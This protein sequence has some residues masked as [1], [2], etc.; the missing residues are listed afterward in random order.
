MDQN[1]QQS[2]LNLTAV[3]LGPGDPELVTIKGLRAIEAAG[4]IFVPR[5]RDGDASLALRIARPWLNSTRQQIVEL[6][7]PMTRDPDLL[8]PAWRAA[9][10]QIADELQA[11]GRAAGHKAR[12]A[13]LLLG[14]PLL[15]GTFIY[16]WGELAARYPQIAVTIIPGVTS[17]AAAAAR[18]GIPLG[19]T[20][21]RVSIVPASYETDAGQLRRLL[22]DA[23]TV[24][25]MKVGRVLPQVLA[26][27]AE[28]GLL[29][30]AVYVERIGMPEELIVRD[31]RALRGQQRPYLSLLIVRRK[32]TR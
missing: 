10:D 11:V 22:S 7:L 9:A 21:D 1:V 20:N 12:G 14:D 18:A 8:A 24:I 17:F 27:L 29:D 5:S 19:T 2:H 13:Y 15:Y 28:L 32:L 30:A 3:G 23:D 16:L 4:V 26:A 6:G 25:L 31:L